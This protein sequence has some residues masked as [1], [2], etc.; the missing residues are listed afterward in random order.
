M[1]TIIPMADVDKE[2]KEK[3]STAK[4]SLM[5]NSEYTFFATA[6]IRLNMS[7]TRSIKTLA[8]DGLNLFINP[9]FVIGLSNRQ[10]A[11]G[12]LHEVMHVIYE[13]LNRI[14]SRDHRMWNIATDYVINNQLDSMG[15]DVIEGVCLDHQYD[16]MSADE[17]YARIKDKEKKQP[18]STSGLSPNFDDFM[19][20][21]AGNDSN[22]NPFQSVTPDQITQQVQDIVDQ[23]IVAS[24]QA[25]AKAM[26]NVPGQVLRDYQ[27]RTRP[28]IDW[29]TALAD[30]MYAIGRQGSSFK[31]PS[32]RGLAQNLTLPGK[33]GK[34]LGRIDF[35]IDTSGSVSNDMFTQFVSEI[36]HVFDRFKPKEIGIMQF[37]HDLKARDIVKN[38]EEFRQIKMKG[39][40]GTQI[41]PVLH[42]LKDI[43]SRA[44]VVLTDGYF[45][46]T[47]AMDPK[48]P[49]I[50]CIYDNPTWRPPFGSVIHFKVEDLGKGK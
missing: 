28:I 45:H 31:R 48:K 37:D 13:H 15:L 46:L 23:S 8:T 22:G 32:R 17:V 9:D 36:A 6:L 10:I 12:L 11:F 29:K 44:M 33:L 19:Q 39:G 43:P 40:G 24:Q 30:Q 47:K 49:V 20:T 2:A 35:A 38:T 42:K 41:E 3:V 14:G 4:I 18:G 50:W 5:T 21:P 26:G 27:E 7:Y 16:N 1:T 34:G 25:G